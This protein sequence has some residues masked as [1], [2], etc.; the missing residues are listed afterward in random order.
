[1]GLFGRKKK[2]FKKDE[3]LSEQEELFYSYFDKFKEEYDNLKDDLKSMEEE[4]N[5]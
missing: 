3:K 5:D 2:E 1:M 4:D